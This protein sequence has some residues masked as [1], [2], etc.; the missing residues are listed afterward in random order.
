[1]TISWGH[2]HPPAAICVAEL[3]LLSTTV[4]CPQSLQGEF[5]WIVFFSEVNFLHLSNFVLERF[6]KRIFANTTFPD[7]NIFNKKSTWTFTYWAIAYLQMVRTFRAQSLMHFYIIQFHAVSWLHE[8]KPLSWGIGSLNLL[9]RSAHLAPVWTNCLGWNTSRSLQPEQVLEVSTGLLLASFHNSR[10]VGYARL[11][12]SWRHRF[13]KSHGRWVEVR[14]H[15]RDGQYRFTSEVAHFLALVVWLR[16]S[17][18]SIL[19]RWIQ[20]AM[21]GTRSGCLAGHCFSCLATIAYTWARYLYVY[22]WETHNE[23]WG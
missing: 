20:I 19:Y 13:G 9:S 11:Q 15:R 21:T 8:I 6:P 18:S 16:W 14:I 2:R 5:C 4:P 3:V 10:Y 17:C 12:G 23:L 7:L 1:M 22:L